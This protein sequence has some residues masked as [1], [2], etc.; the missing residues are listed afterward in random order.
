MLIDGCARRV[1]MDPPVRVCVTG[2]EDLDTKV[3]FVS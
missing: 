2:G 1:P 3:S